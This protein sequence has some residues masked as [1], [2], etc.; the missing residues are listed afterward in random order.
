MEGSRNR[1]ERNSQ[2]ISVV[3]YLKRDEEDEDAEAEE[4][5]DEEWEEIKNMHWKF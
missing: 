4:E 5:K 1:I 2:S 3:Q